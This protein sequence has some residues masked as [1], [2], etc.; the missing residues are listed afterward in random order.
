MTSKD[1][2]PGR[3]PHREG[4]DSVALSLRR[5]REAL[6]LTTREVA[7]RIGVSPAFITLIE[8][9]RKRPSPENA[10]ALAKVLGLPEEPLVAWV[11]MGGGYDR[12]SRAAELIAHYLRG[13]AGGLPL[14]GAKPGARSSY[15]SY[16]MSRL[17]GGRPTR[18]AGRAIE[19]L[20]LAE[21]QESQ[22][23]AATSDRIVEAISGEQGR[24]VLRLPLLAE[25]ADPEG[26]GSSRPAAIDT[27][28]ID[29][30]L[31]PA[32]LGMGHAWAYRISDHGARHAPDALAAGDVVVLAR[33]GWPLVPGNLH[34]VLLDGRIELSRVAAKGDALV[35]L[36]ADGVE[37]LRLPAP[38]T[39]PPELRGRVV[40]VVRAAASG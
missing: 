33:P 11:E 8:T 28:A 34:A 31:L 19:P 20:S 29:R 4:P 2:R 37:L 16:M 22:S 32:D 25:G 5:A 3:P 40:L 9:G 15:I 6:G 13:Q 39:A 17:L 23:A 35:V 14:A 7:S 1:A 10:R 38:E 26:A 27:I 21:P 18:P 24:G 30:A 36:L 12:K